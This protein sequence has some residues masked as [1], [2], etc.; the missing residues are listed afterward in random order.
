M[1]GTPRNHISTL[2]AKRVCALRPRRHT[3]SPAAGSS[4]LNA[5]AP[6]SPP[7][8]ARNFLRLRFMGLL[9]LRGCPKRGLTPLYLD[10]FRIIK[11]FLLPSA[12]ANSVGRPPP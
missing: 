2:T 3:S 7:L 10:R 8:A 6:T 4:G 12:E 1:N 5:A 9:P 11:T